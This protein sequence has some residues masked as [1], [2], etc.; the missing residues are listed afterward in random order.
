MVSLASSSSYNSIH[1]TRCG[2]LSFYIKVI[3]SRMQ[4]HTS[5]DVLEKNTLYSK[6]PYSRLSG[7][8]YAVFIASRNMRAVSFKHR[9][10]SARLPGY[11]LCQ[12]RSQYSIFKHT[13]SPGERT[14]TCLGLLSTPLSSGHVAY[15]CYDASFAPVHFHMH[16][17]S[18]AVT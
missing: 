17:P 18:L 2:A 6:F 10:M 5:I 11:G 1:F 9:S 15:P 14:S 7:L 12:R 13:D 16:T 4:A 3:D 8:L